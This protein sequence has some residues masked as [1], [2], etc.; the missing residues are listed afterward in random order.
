MAQMILHIRPADD[1]Q[2]DANTLS[3]RGV[4]SVCLPLTEIGKLSPKLPN[5]SDISAL[6]FTSRH[7]VLAFVDCCLSSLDD[8]ELFLA[9]SAYSGL[10]HT[11]LKDTKIIETLY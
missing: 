1:S 4:Q 3:R 11:N 2:R 9:I 8:S 10:I 7:A 5:T 6:I